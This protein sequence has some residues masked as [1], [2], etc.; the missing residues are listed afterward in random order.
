MI[1]CQTHCSHSAFSPNTRSFHHLQALKHTLVLFGISTVFHYTY[2]N[3]LD[4]PS[5]ELLDCSLCLHSLSKDQLFFK[6]TQ[7]AS[8]VAGGKN[9]PALAGDV[10]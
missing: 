9:S 8:L 1:A 10:G 5:E 3:F 7:E 2:S 4:C 6:T